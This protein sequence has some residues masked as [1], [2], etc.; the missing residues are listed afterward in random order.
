M[1]LL[2]K[3]ED[4]ELKKM[5]YKKQPNGMKTIDEYTY[6]NDFKVCF[7]DVSDNVS[8]SAYGAEINSIKRL[9]SI[10]NELEFF[11]LPKMDS[12]EDNISKY[13]I[14]YNDKNYK[15]KVVKPHY[16]DIQSL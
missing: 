9:S 14:S 8:I 3:L 6:I 4:I 11:L 5:S 12:V 16:I 2:R 7:Q 10:R 13:V 15:I 1:K